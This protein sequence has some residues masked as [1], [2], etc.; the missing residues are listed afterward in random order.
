[1]SRIRANQILNG[2][3]TGAP[4]FP[5]GLTGTTGTFS[6]TVSVGGT[7]TY[8]D[9]TSV[10][11][12]GIITAQTGIHVTSGKLLIGTTSAK[13]SGIGTMANLYVVSPTV[14]GTAS[15]VYVAKFQGNSSVGDSEALISCAAGY[16]ISD[17]DN[18]GH[19][20][21]GAHRQGTGNVGA[22]VVKTG[23]NSLERLRITGD[24]YVTKPQ[25]PAFFATHTT[26]SGS[27]V[28]GVLTYDTAGVGYYNNGSH[29]T[30]GTGKFTAPVAGIYHFHF[31]GFLENSA[32]G[33]NFSTNIVRTRSA[34][35]TILA[36]QYGFN[37]TAGNY[38]PS[39]SLHCT[40]YLEAA[41]TVHIDATGKGFHG[42]N[43]YYFGGYLV[44]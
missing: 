1:M 29:L 22:F 35:E 27:P 39:I 34:T 26:N 43:G 41:D 2:A 40:N 37:D 11:S 33:G 6:G 25:T 9:V 12:V 38:G 13:A 20:H 3:G 42:A 31:H 10:D 14:T 8:E 19:V 28:T 4:N 15:T 17:S 18:E 44:G 23:L 36:R 5:Q 32:S 24:G 16:P 30:V 7:L 21:F